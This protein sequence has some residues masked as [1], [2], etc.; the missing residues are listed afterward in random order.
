MISRTANSEAT[1]DELKEIH[2][3]LHDM[4]VSRDEIEKKL[5]S[6]VNTTGKLV[7]NQENF[8]LNSELSQYYNPL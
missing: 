6:Y 1:L 7:K 8:I 5:N 3:L 2:L 4:S